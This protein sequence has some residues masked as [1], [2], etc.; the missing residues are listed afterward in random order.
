[1]QKRKTCFSLTFLTLSSVESVY[2]QS[3]AIILCLL[4]AHSFTLF[5]S[6]QKTATR[7]VLPPVAANNGDEACCH[8]MQIVVDP[9]TPDIIWSRTQIHRNLVNEDNQNHYPIPS[10]NDLRINNGF[11]LRI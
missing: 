6:N 2:R 11:I 8:A 9:E 3:G 5:I 4:I 7:T 10:I 1:V